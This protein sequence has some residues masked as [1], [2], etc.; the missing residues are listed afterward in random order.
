MS[1]LV[2]SGYRGATFLEAVT[3]PPAQKAV[4]VTFDDA[5]R[6]I[7]ELAFPIL[8]R[9]GLPGTVFVP[10]DF[11]GTDIPMAWAGNDRWLHGPYESEM[12]CMSWEELGQLADAGWEI[13]SHTKSHPRL[14]E[15]DDATLAAELSGSREECE[16]RLERPCRSMAH[17]YGH[18]DERVLEATREAGYVAAADLPDRFNRATPFMCPRVG[19]YH[20]DADRRFRLK[21]ARATRRL[22]T[23][24]AW[25][26]IAG[27]RRA[28]RQAH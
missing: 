24:P 14:T 16:R 28:L 4:A 2:G 22:R 10:T 26:A 3:G 5:Y 12:L 6:S 21:V 7:M 18:P 8:S 9:W 23:S 17:P 1:F 20:R 25:S 11:A 15:L 19:V 27:A 13:G